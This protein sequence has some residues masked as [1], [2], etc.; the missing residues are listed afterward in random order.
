MKQGK[1]SLPN[2]VKGSCGKAWI[3]NIFEIV[4]IG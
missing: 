3:C 2:Y 1:T 4:G